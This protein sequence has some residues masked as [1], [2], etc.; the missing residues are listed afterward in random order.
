MVPRLPP[1]VPAHP[2]PL[3]AERMKENGAEPKLADAPPV[4]K[5]CP[6]IT[7]DAR[8]MAKLAEEFVETR[9]WPS[10]IPPHVPEDMWNTV[11][12]YRVGLQG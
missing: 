3:E 8:L 9:E 10:T 7:D 5:D 2:K 4:E 11:H 12:E 6:S 1:D